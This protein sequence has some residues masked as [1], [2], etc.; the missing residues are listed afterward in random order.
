VTTGITRRVNISFYNDQPKKVALVVLNIALFFGSI[1]LLEIRHQRRLRTHVP[2]ISQS[3]EDMTMEEFNRRV[4][5]RE[6]L[7]IIDNL[8][9]KV[10]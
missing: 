6:M 7:V 2:L 10:D 3:D 5:N 9:L 4:S 1:F 8:V